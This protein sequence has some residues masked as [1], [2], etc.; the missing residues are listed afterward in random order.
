MEQAKNKKNIYS[1]TIG[2][3]AYNEEANIFYLLNSLIVQKED[4][5]AIEKILVVSDGSSDKT[6]EK[7][8]ACKDS[9]IT[10]IAGKKREGKPSRLNQIFSETQSDI[11][12]VLDADIKLASDEVIKKLVEPLIGGKAVSASGFAAPIAA[13]TTVQKIATAGVEIWDS[14]R[15]SKYSSL[16]Y[17]SEGRI[18]AFTKEVYRDMRFPQ[19]SADE[20]FSFLYCAAKKYPFI[21]IE[22]ALVYYN[23]PETLS[24]YL[25]QYKRFIKSKG[26]QESSY[27]KKFVKKYYTIGFNAKLIYLIQNIIKNPFWT[28]L[29]LGIVPLTRIL[30]AMDKGN[31]EA[32][33]EEISSSKKIDAEA[34]KNKIF[35][36]SY[37]SIGNP[38]YNGGGASSIHE[39]AKRL[40]DRYD[41]KV[42]CG[43]YPS[44]KKHA[45]DGVFYEYAGFNFLGPKLSQLIFQLFLPYYA[46]TGDFDVWIESFTPPFSISFLTIFTKK[47]VI[48]L[49]HMLVGEEMSRKYKIP[50]CAAEKIGLK[51]YNNFIVLTKEIG[52]KIRKINP[53]AL[54]E[55]IPNGVKLD[56]ARDQSVKKHLLYMG[57]IEVNQKG[58]DLLLE[59]YKLILK[60]SDYSLIIAGSGIKSEEKKLAKMIR[61]LGISG[62]VKLTGRIDGAEKA[63]MFREA[64]AVIVPSRFETFSLTALEALAYGIWVISFNIEGLKWLPEDFSYKIKPFDVKEMAEA[65]KN[66]AGKNASKKINFDKLKIFL[67][68]YDWSVIAEKYIKHID[69]AL[70]HKNES[71]RINSMIQEIISK[72]IPCV[73]ISPHL[74]D[75]ILS[76]G[77][78]LL[79]L[80]SKTEVKIVSI[81]TE[82]R[83]PPYTFSVRANLKMCGGYKNAQDLFRLRK[84]EDIEA[85]A[86][87]GARHIHFGFQDASFRKKGG[88]SLFYKIIGGVFPEAEYIYPIYR[89]NIVSGNISKNDARTLAIIG[90][91]LRRLKKRSENSI[92]FCPLGVGGHVDHVIVS[93]ICRKVFPKVVFWEDYPYNLKPKKKSF[94]SMISLG[95]LD[96]SDFKGEKIK[97]ISFYKSQLKSMFPH[98]IVLAP[99]N[100]YAAPEK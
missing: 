27:D 12:V 87:I 23:L 10:L 54:I 37:D 97:M 15:R 51:K 22:E 42:I 98:G 61:G 78:L 6:E 40:V 76:A 72:K 93:E 39:V 2:I 82:A 96:I 83:L 21:F 13:R 74:D 41:V 49:V 38:Y 77:G 62:K 45:V 56:L 20:A 5:F 79:R 1:V 52:Q 47:P 99:E 69:R 18:R 71:I 46:I 95:S 16:L 100:Y 14:A 68:D 81:F 25:K 44:A 92:V 59:G 57:R 64:A 4:G 11:V 28:M 80:A 19:A 75:A 29:Y 55:V 53:H 8:E 88:G 89:F 91:K 85:C 66:L 67:K 3:P 36:S 50:F 9:R 7:I 63:R 90:K 94:T 32:R 26:I 35:F 24:D 17:L 84:E 30:C 33:W 70:N 73:F 58:L 34:G 65:M 31:R 48:G 43:N 86:A 60:K